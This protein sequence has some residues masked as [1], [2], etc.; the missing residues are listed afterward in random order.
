MKRY[1]YAG[2]ASAAI[3]FCSVAATPAFAQEVSPPSVTSPP[4]VADEQKDATPSAALNESLPQS[5]TVDAQPQVPVSPSDITPHPQTAETQSETQTADAPASTETA[6]ADKPATAPA[7]ANEPN[8]ELALND[9]EIPE[10]KSSDKA[11]DSF[12]AREL[13]KLAA[14]PPLEE[15]A[16]VAPANQIASADPATADEASDDEAPAEGVA[17]NPAPATP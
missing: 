17:S 7:E 15:T 10:P 14:K 16:S 5:S 6:E 8:T 12:A 13:A 4:I 2:I 3:S 11:A 9:V 1:L